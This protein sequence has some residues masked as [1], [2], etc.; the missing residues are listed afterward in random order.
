MDTNTSLLL[1]IADLNAQVR[2]LQEENNRLRS[3]A[4][5]SPG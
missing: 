1:L 2:R 3:E 5:T 4:Q